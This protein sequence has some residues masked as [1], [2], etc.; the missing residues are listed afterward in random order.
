VSKK[1]VKSYFEVFA[2]DKPLESMTYTTQLTGEKYA[3]IDGISV[4]ASR[5]GWTV[6]PTGTLLQSHQT[7]GWKHL[8]GG[9]GNQ[10]RC[11]PE[12]GQRR[13]TKN[14]STR[15]LVSVEQ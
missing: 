8:H 1:P 6:V 14:R 12:N 7:E 3:E 11:G 2:A 13:I 15:G 4:T 5:A 10:A 9:F